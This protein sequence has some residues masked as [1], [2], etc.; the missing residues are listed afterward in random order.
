MFVI[1]VT[2]RFQPTPSHNPFVTWV[3]TF[4]F[5]AFQLRLRLRLCLRLQFRV[6][7]SQMSSSECSSL[8]E[9]MPGKLRFCRESAIQQRVQRSTGLAHR[10]VANRYV[11][12][13]S[14]SFN[15][16]V[17]PGFT[18]TL[19]RG[20]MRIF[21]STKGGNEDSV[22]SVALTISR[23]NSSSRIT[24]DT[25]STTPADLRQAVRTS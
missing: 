18:R 24:L 9:P 17:Y 14:G 23:M 12:I 8:E 16:T 10:V 7:A 13:L 2:L 5:V 6:S 3:H 22:D 20:W 15:L 4:G 1:L 21:L 25:F 19:Y 11:H